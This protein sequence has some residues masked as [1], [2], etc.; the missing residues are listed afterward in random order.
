[1][2]GYGRDC[3][4]SSYVS[5]G[6]DVALP[7]HAQALALGG[8]RAPSRRTAARDSSRVRDRT[9]PALNARSGT[10]EG[11]ESTGDL[12]DY[13]TETLLRRPPRRTPSCASCSP[14]RSVSGSVA[15][16]ATSTPASPRRVL[17]RVH[18]PRPSA[19]AES[20]S[21][22]PDHLD[23]HAGCRIGCAAVRSYTRLDAVLQR[24]CI[25]GKHKDRATHLR[26]QQRPDGEIRWWISATLGPMK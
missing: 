18:R 1:M 16:A 22:E 5:A 3:R 25:T 19:A 23:G 2:A 7:A 4:P 21:L 11:M 8:L 13:S 17:R 14:R 12:Y 24:Q 15:D 20:Q 6:R 10:R 9:R 26:S